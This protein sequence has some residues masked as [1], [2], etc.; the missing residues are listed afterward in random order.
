M[1]EEDIFEEKKRILEVLKEA[2]DVKIKIMNCLIDA[3][4]Y[5]TVYLKYLRNIIFNLKKN[6]AVSEK[7]NNSI[8]KHSATLTNVTDK[9]MKWLSTENSDEDYN[10]SAYE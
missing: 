7:I 4:A 1:K 3:M 8:L 9:I 6:S 5:E 2:D 10:M